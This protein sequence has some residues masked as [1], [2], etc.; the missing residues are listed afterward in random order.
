MNTTYEST[1]AQNVTDNERA[2]R[3]ILGMGLICSI[4]IGGI[5]TPTVIFGL[6]VVSFYFVITAILGIDPIYGL[7]QQL[8][9]VLT[10]SRYE[11]EQACA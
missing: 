10:V 1:Q 3:A 6:T 4:L 7:L 11:T 8:M 9:Q 5:T 2:F